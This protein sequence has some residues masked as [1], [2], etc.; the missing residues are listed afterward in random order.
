LHALINEIN[1]E[2]KDKKNESSTRRHLSLRKLP[3]DLVQH[4]SWMD[5]QQHVSKPVSLISPRTHHR[6]AHVQK[7]EIQ[8][9]NIAPIKNPSLGISF[10]LH[11]CILGSRKWWNLRINLIK[12][13]SKVCKFNSPVNISILEHYERWFPSKLQCHWLKIASC[14]QFK[15]NFSSFCRASKC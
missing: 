10:L 6:P 9:S 1:R 2:R 4:L 13:Q 3:E 14:S 8:H 12:E 5:L 11:T 7:Y 15:Y